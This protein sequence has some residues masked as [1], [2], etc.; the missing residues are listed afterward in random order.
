M[1]HTNLVCPECAQHVG[2]VPRV[3][4]FG[5]PVFQCPACR[6]QARLPLATARAV[7]YLV[8]SLLSIG[9]CIQ[10]LASGGIP[11]L[12]VIPGLMIAAL[13]MDLSIRNRWRAA[14]IRSS[15]LPK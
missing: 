5:F 12:G 3:N 10:V 15:P 9:F 2:A 4:F 11:I 6:R 8:I 7:I 14:R 1:P 13:I